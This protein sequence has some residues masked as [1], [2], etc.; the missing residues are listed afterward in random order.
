[1]QLPAFDHAQAIVL[2]KEK[3]KAP[4]SSADIAAKAH[5]R[6]DLNQ[7]PE[8][9]L[10]FCLAF[11]R[12]HAE[13]A[14]QPD[15]TSQ[16]PNYFVRAAINFNIA[17][18]AATAGPMLTE[19]TQMDWQKLGLPN[20]SHMSE[21]A[22]E[23]LLLNQKTSAPAFAALFEQAV[24]RCRELGWEFPKIHPKQ[25][26]LLQTA[27]TLNLPT[28]VRRLVDLILKR[29]PISRDTRNLLQSAESYLAQQAP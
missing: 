2:L 29:R 12:A 13:I 19:V 6:W 14:V 16:A 25:E 28:V 26:L 23:Q 5:R 15:S 21:W 10:L 27:I 9:A 8:A 22:F 24:L 18:D 7:H 4:L 11:E 3:A 17:G 1:M 20:D